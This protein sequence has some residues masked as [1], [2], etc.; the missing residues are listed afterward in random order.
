MNNIHFVK[1]SDLIDIAKQIKKDEEK[2][3]SEKPAMVESNFIKKEIYPLIIDK[4]RKLERT[5][6]RKIIRKF[7]LKKIDELMRF[8]K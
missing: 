7:K 3:L 8:L 2:T 4:G 5:R 6:I 1:N